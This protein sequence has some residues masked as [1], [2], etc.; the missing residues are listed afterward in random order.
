MLEK[1]QSAYCPRCNTQ[2]YRGSPIHVER[3]LALALACIVLL[4]PAL[5]HPFLSIRLIGEMITASLWD[6]IV[7][8]FNEGFASLAFFVGL[9]TIITPISVLAATLTADWSLRTLNNTWLKRSLRIIHYFKHWMMLDVF[10]I[11]IAISSFKLQD[12][13]DLHFRP[14]LIFLG[15]LQI[16]MLLLISR[17]SN[18]RYWEVFDLKSGVESRDHSAVVETKPETLLDCPHCH[19]TQ[20]AHGECDR[21]GT[22]IKQSNDSKMIRTTWL[23]LLIATIAIIPANLVPISILITNGQRLED[24]ILSGI[25]SLIENGMS[26]IA[27]II[28]VAS[29]LVPIFKILGIAYLLLAVQF[30][31][32]V[33]HKQRMGIYFVVKWIGKWSMMDIL[34]IAIMLTLVDRGQILNFTPGFGAIAFGVVV[35]FTMLATET[36]KPNFIWRNINEKEL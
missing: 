18:R 31:R 22:H 28:F 35:V 25:A 32:K 21:C 17:L 36:L 7:A 33:Y 4:Y 19:L 34:V 5:F 29:I 20:F 26:G 13:A 11:S 30:D 3:N 2:L 6:G 10:L 27:L 12:Y 14:G 24:T 1:Q 23:Y 8:L 9:T 16:L 15:V